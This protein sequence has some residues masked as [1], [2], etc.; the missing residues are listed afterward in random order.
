MAARH[1]L[2]HT[3][4]TCPRIMTDPTVQG[5]RNLDYGVNYG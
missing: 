1:V 4:T 2:R 3:V 5:S